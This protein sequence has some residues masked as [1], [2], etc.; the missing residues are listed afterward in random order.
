MYQWYFDI[1]YILQ[2]A[3]Y[4][5]IHTY[6]CSIIKYYTMINEHVNEKNVM[7]IYNFRCFFFHPSSSFP[8]LFRFL[9][10]LG[11]LFL[12]YILSLCLNFCLCCLYFVLCPFRV[13]FMFSTSICLRILR[14]FCVKMWWGKSSEGWIIRGWVIMGWV[15]RG[16]S[17]PRG[18]SS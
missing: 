17:N 2:R 6:N 15:N 9:F 18:E 5:I 3:D 7:I 1:I 14:T 13:F 10:C 11:F 4:C 12:V 16:V 8:S